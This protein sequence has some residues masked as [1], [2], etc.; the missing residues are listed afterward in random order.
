ML[1]SRPGSQSWEHWEWEEVGRMLRLV[2]K[3]GRD[4]GLTDEHLSLPVK[5]HWERRDSSVVTLLLVKTQ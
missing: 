3:R 2:V 5:A 4:G 1:S